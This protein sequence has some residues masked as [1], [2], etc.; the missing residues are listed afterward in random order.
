MAL[1]SHWHPGIKGLVHHSDRGVQY[2]SNEY[3]QYLTDHNILIS[4]SGKGNPLDNPYLY[5]DVEI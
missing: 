4:M 1:A 3:V 5:K 2:A